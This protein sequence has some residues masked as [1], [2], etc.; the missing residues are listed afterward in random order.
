M[1]HGFW[2]P[3]DK[4]PTAYS[5]SLCVN[6]NTAADFHAWAQWIEDAL[7]TIG[8][9]AVTADTGQTLPS[10][11]PVATQVGQHKGFRIYKMTDDLSA[12]APVFM[13]IDFGSGNWIPSVNGPPWPCALW[14]TIGTGSDG[15]GTITGTMLSDRYVPNYGASNAGVLGGDSYASV[16]NNRCCIALWVGAG[17]QYFAPIA[18]SVERS[19]DATGAYTGDGL[20]VVHSTTWGIGG[21]YGIGLVYS[22]Y[23]AIGKPLSFQQPIDVGISYIHTTNTPT[24]TYLGDRGVGILYHFFGV[25]V[26]PGTHWLIA[27]Q[28]DFGAQGFA[29]VNLYGQYHPYITVALTPVYGVIANM[30]FGGSSNAETYRNV[31]MRYD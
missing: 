19:R 3:T 24:P 26:Q 20:L 21:G 10:A 4:M 23:L 18:F 29:N 15:N 7:V 25:A 16:D 22:P 12:T 13:R 28:N 2:L 8:G 31:L 17:A 27:N 11:L 30:G 1:G 9:W 14:L 5:P 6:S